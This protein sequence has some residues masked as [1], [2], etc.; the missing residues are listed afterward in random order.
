MY[1]LTS[2]LPF[3]TYIEVVPGGKLDFDSGAMIKFLDDPKLPENVHK[4][5]FEK[6][7]VLAVDKKDGEECLLCTYAKDKGKK[8]AM[9][10]GQVS[11]N[12]YKGGYDSEL[13]LEGFFST[14]LINNG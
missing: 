5:F 10:G 12:P 11:D 1:K 13:W 7:D 9:N 3:P 14:R 6:Y 2:L 8:A 4:H